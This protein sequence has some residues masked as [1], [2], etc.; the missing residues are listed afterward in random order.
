MEVKLIIN[1]KHPNNTYL[2]HDEKKCLIIDP[3]LEVEKII[4]TINNLNLKPIGILL[5]HG[6]YDHIYSVREIVNMYD[7]AI[8]CSQDCADMIKD[9]KLN[10]S[11]TSNNCPSEF[12]V[13][14]D[15]IIV[16]EGQFEVDCFKLTAVANPGHTSGC[17]SYINDNHCFTGDFIF[18]GRIGKTIYPTSSDV[19]MKS[20]LN[21]FKKMNPTLTIYPGHGESSFL[22]IELKQNKYL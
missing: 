9:S 22:D 17:M 15:P 12:T 3:S 14:I 6:H 8:Y 10:M 4:N 20:S 11:K 13:D 19:M 5:T 1:G 21:K 2:L 16:D 18:K 7:V